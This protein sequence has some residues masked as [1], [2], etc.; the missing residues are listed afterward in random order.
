MDINKLDTFGKRVEFLLDLKEIQK[1]DL[2]TAINV[3]PT[4]ISNYIND[5]R[6][7][8]LNTLAKIADYLNVNSD[9]LLM[10]TNDYQTYIS[11]EIDGN[12]VEITFDDEKLHLTENQINDFFAHLK[13]V[14]FNPKVFFE[15]P[16]NK[17]K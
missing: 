5:N 7:P 3:S 16:K 10:R 9:F 11:K 2:A 17:N 14:G 6:K 1:Q 8:D 13:Q 12:I 4:T 15:N